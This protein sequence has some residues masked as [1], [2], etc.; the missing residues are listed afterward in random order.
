MGDYV[1]NNVYVNPQFLSQV[2]PRIS[3]RDKFVCLNPNPAMN[4]Y[5]QNP[6]AKY[7]YYYHFAERIVVARVPSMVRQTHVRILWMT[8][9]IGLTWTGALQ[10]HLSDL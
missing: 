2:D 6:L 3:D 8:W 5:C 7:L 1:F 9:R 4:F 10:Q